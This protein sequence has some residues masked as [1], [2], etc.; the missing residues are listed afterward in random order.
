MKWTI[1][2]VKIV[3]TTNLV[4]FKMS[5]LLKFRELKY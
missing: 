3:T 5:E 4:S 1:T 2:K